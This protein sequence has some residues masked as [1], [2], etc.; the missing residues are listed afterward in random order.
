MRERAG[1]EWTAGRFQ[2]AH[3]A[4]A[5]RCVGLG[6]VRGRR[7]RGRVALVRGLKGKRL[8]YQQPSKL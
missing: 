1:A 8:T 4:R 6:L 7:A 5:E 3:R 2:D